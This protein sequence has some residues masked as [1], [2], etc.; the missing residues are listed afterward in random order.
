MATQF[1]ANTQDIARSVTN[2]LEE[3]AASKDQ[4]STLTVNQVEAVYK[5]IGKFIDFMFKK[6][7]YDCV[8]AEIANFGTVLRNNTTDIA[9]FIPA[10]Q[11]QIETHISKPMLSK[12]PEPYS[13][14]ELIFSKISSVTQ[15]SESL[16]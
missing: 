10:S 12:I 6:K 2:A 7:H 8:I 13:R 9:E 5:C 1:V 16:I 15:L 14:Q 3:R 4:A 11:L